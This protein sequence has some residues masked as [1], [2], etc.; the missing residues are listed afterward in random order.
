MGVTCSIKNG[1]QHSS[2]LAGLIDHKI[3]FGS[4]QLSTNDHSFPH[5]QWLT[6]CVKTQLRLTGGEETI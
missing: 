3:Y 6:S 2:T 1:I 5:D 4:N